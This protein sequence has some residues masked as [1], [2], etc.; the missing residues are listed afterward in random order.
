MADLAN[1][2]CRQ[3][4]HPGYTRRADAL[5][6]LQQGHRT[7][8]YP[9]LL[10]AASQQFLQLLLILLGHFDAQGWTGHTQVC[11][12]TVPIGTDCLALLQTV[13]DLASGAHVLSALAFPAFCLTCVLLAMLMIA[14]SAFIA[15]A[16]ARA[17]S[18]E[19]F[20]SPMALGCFDTRRL[21]SAQSTGIVSRTSDFWL[22]VQGRST[23]HRGSACRR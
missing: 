2:L 10:D 23:V 9:H 7:Q 20:H 21:Y 5:G 6:Q 8:H 22:C 16:Q 1:R 18:N 17:S 4:N 3:R 12:K 14:R 11:P 13:I 19:I 15:L